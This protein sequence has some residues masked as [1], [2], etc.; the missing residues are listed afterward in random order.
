MR[1]VLPGIEQFSG[2]AVGIRDVVRP[3]EDGL[4]CVAV[5]GEARVTETPQC[6]GVLRLH[7]RKHPRPLDLFEPEVGII[8][9]RFECR[10]RI[11][12][13]HG[14]LLQWRAGGSVGN[15]QRAAGTGASLRCGP[16]GQSPLGLD[17]PSRCCPP[18]S[19]EPERM[20]SGHY[21][22][23]GPIAVVVAA[24]PKSPATSGSGNGCI[25]TCRALPPLA[26]LCA[27]GFQ[28]KL[29]R[30]GTTPPTASLR[31]RLRMMRC[32][33]LPVSRTVSTKYT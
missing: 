30:P 32:L 25:I 16:S 17:S 12:V 3:I 8:I 27:V 31:P 14:E 15:S 4:E 13:R 22:L 19:T 23:E 28:P 18:G 24:V 33:I 9:R 6:R 11:E 21:G 2:A 29:R 7:K 1:G 10:P 20:P 26:P 5:S